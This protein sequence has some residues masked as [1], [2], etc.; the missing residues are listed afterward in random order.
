MTD[1]KAAELILPGLQARVSFEK[2]L[3]ELSREAVSRRLLR[4]FHGSVSLTLYQRF[5]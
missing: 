3:V 2:T 5:I 1:Q 4:H